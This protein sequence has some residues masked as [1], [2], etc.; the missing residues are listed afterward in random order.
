MGEAQV[1]WKCLHFRKRG[2]LVSVIRAGKSVLLHSIGKG[3][4]SDLQACYFLDNTQHLPSPSNMETFGCGTMVLN[5]AEQAKSQVTTCSDFS[6][7]QVTT[8]SLHPQFPFSRYSDAHD[9]NFEPNYKIL[10]ST[11]IH[12]S[13]MHFSLTSWSF[14]LYSQQTWFPGHYKVT[15]CSDFVVSL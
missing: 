5:G 13:K 14:R 8:K 1:F 3:T 12:F 10:S 2:P 9:R 6:S 7:L 4:L 11:S 15:T